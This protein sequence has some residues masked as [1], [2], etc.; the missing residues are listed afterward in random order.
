MSN[1]DVEILSPAKFVIPDG[2][3]LGVRV[4]LGNAAYLTQ[5]HDTLYLDKKQAAQLADMLAAWA[6]NAKGLPNDE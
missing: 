5:G 1:N 3:F 2:M 4:S 6:H